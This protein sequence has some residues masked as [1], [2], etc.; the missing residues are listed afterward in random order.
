MNLIV[1]NPKNEQEFQFVSDLLMNLG[2]EN[3]V[4]DEEA[5]EDIGI[6]LLLK[7]TDRSDVV[8]E[9]EVLKKLRG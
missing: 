4:L 3:K 1:I 7:E 9:E 2:I 6:S 8:S 5:K